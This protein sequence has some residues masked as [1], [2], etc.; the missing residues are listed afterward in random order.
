MADSDELAIEGRVEQVREGVLEGWTWSPGDAERMRVRVLLDGS[1]LGDTVAELSRPTLV[2]AGV[3]DG[4]HGFRFELPDGA[5]QPGRHLLRVQVDQH[6]LAP[7]AGFTVST[8]REHSQWRGVRF[9]IDHPDAPAAQPAIDGRVEQVRDGV[10]E[11][12]AWCPDWP[13]ERL[14]LRILLDGEEVGATIAELRR[15]SLQ[16][17]GIGDGAHAFRFELPVDRAHPGRRTLRVEAAGEA[18]EPAAGFVVENGRSDDPWYGARFSLEPLEATVMQPI[19]SPPAHVKDPSDRGTPQTAPAVLGLDGWLFDGAILAAGAAPDALARLEGRVA[20]LL[21]TLDQLDGRVTQTGVK[22]LPVL[23]PTKEFVYRGRLAASVR[24]GVNTRPGY[25]VARGLA[26]HSRLDTLDLLPALM[27]GGER[28]PVFSPTFGT[29]SDWGSFCA[30]RGLIKRVAMILPG[31]S[32][33][34]A[35]D[36]SRVLSAPAK[37]WKGEVAMAT[38]T[39]LVPCPAE[40]LPEPPSEPVVVAPEGGAQRT[41]HEHLARL[42]AAFVLGWEQPRNRDLGRALFVGDPAHAPLVEWAARHFR[43]TV[44]I[45]ADSPVIDLIA[46]ERP[47]VIVY[48]VQERVLLTPA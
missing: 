44:L 36:A 27:A 37:R 20:S 17:A 21:D 46:L 39:G 38:E 2:A 41:P 1:E 32:S 25:M 6:A 34:I 5:A 43:F 26:D 48:L 19:A 29:L 45:G 47:D 35:L 40:Q 11:G 13:Q 7:A 4:R 16:E 18:L 8:E 12:W 22:L 15:P 23:V 14:G 24:G 31:I 10:L 33:P 3:G 9:A 28:Q 30:Y 42:E